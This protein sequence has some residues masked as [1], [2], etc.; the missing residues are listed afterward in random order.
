MSLIHYLYSGM[1]GFCFSFLLENIILMLEPRNNKSR[2]YQNIIVRVCSTLIPIIC[3]Y[4][5]GFT[6]HA[7]LAS[8][9][10][11]A[12]LA[13]IIIDIKHQILPDHLTLTL[14]WMGL[15][16]N[17]FHI[18]TDFYSAIAGAIVGYLSLWGIA[19]L[20]KLWRKVDG[21]GYGDFK[22]LALLGAWFGVGKLIYIV[23]ISSFLGSLVTL[24]LI[25]FG[26]YTKKTPVPFGPYLAIGGWMMLFC[27]RTF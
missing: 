21:M 8:V 9:F 11:L 17:I 6:L 10:S 4:Y 25:L 5:F 27:T 1:W 2:Y 7:I 24:L 12:L 22:M 16:V 15:N 20:Y 3:V 13:L 19:K 18:F 14:L 26:N 23:L